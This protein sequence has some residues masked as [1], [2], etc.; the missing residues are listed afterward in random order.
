M[1]TAHVLSP[2][3]QIAKK[4]VISV[5]VALF[6]TLLLRR[7]V[8][9]EGL[10][11][12]AVQLAPVP[13]RVKQMAESFVQHRNLAQNRLRIARLG[14]KSVALVTGVS[15]EKIYDQF[16]VHA[17]GLPP[18]IRPLLVAAEL[19]AEQELAIL[20]PDLLPLLA[21][22]RRFGK[23]VG[24][25]AESHWSSEQIRQILALAAPGQDFD[26]IYSSADPESI[27]AGGIFA[28]YLTSEGLKP[29]QAIHIG[30]DQDTVLQPF[31]GLTMIGLPQ[32]NSFWEPEKN[33]E[34]IAAR[35]LGGV[36]RGFDWRL[37]DGFN[38][39]R[40]VTL[41]KLAPDMPHQR[42]ATAV[43]GPLMVGFQHHIA[44]QVAALSKPGRKVRL[45]F[46]AR[47]GYLPMRIWNAAGIGAA[48]Y[49]EIN[50]RIAMVA[51]TAGAGGLET[52]QGLI[53][54]MAFVRPSSI[55]DFFKIKLTPKVRAFFDD[56]PDRL[57][58]G[59]DF[60]AAMPRLLGKKA[61]N[62]VSDALRAALIRY[63]TL[64]LGPL[65]GITDLILA[66]IGYTGNIQRGLR[67]VF[68]MEG[69]PIA[70]HGLYLMPHGEAFVELPGEDTVSGYLDDTVLTPA[71]KRAVM[72]DA[73]L[74]EE[75]CCAPVGSAKGYNEAQELRE[76]EV[77]L[78]REIAFC[79]EMQDEVVRYFDEFR[80]QSKNFGLD[81]LRNFANF[82][83]WTAVIL[84]RFVM[85]PT[86]LECQ[87][88]GPLMHDVSLGSRGLIATIT[89]AD[90]RNLMG[91]LP[92]PAV[93][94]IH[95]PPVWLGGS[96]A[97]FSAVAGMAYAMTGFGLPTD[98]MLNDVAVG[99]GEAILVKGERVIPLPVSR[100]L[101]PFGDLRLR[102][103]VLQRDGDCVIALPLRPPFLRGII[104]SLILQSGADI[105]EATTTRHG[106]KLGLD[107]IEASNAVL[108]G[109]F[110]R[111]N[112]NDAMLLV[113]VPALRQT[114][115]LVTIL[116]TPLFDE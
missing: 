71:M 109:S 116:L 16:A 39:L 106:E 32:T 30:V 5:S 112:G 76:P 102:I 8:G 2:G 93:C 85:M 103:P 86:Q 63:L 9:L 92:F 96:L 79:L 54:S 65:D 6:G 89:T 113:K 24:V 15:I 88:F 11:E 3:A 101:T 14:D 75:F 110:F 34:Q 53:K 40:D 50:R 77:R 48:D 72:R 35:L 99:D 46:L 21:E 94:S 64:K 80:Q 43:L 22:A 7:T 87:T 66:D 45:L 51:G 4:N 58:P 97:S 1:G 41:A 33:R 84:S 37:D 49:V 91:A 78:P 108:D 13:D 90:I 70:L 95:H 74:L 69:L 104:R 36:D 60:A 100:T 31:K 25:V 42:V 47:D 28:H 19:A 82:R 67:R 44:Q 68:D 107:K 52:V 98:A 73:P 57:C 62:R 18:A 55:E 59:P 17:L 61:L 114:V 23:R 83:A 56:Y 10:F 20:N 38:L 12:R 29:S 27:E 26:F 81:P 111:S 105:T 115:S